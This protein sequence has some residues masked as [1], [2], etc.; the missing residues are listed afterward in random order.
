M[1]VGRSSITFTVQSQKIEVPVKSNYMVRIKPDEQDKVEDP[2]KE[3]S[4]IQKIIKHAEIHGQE[5]LKDVEE[6]LKTDCTADHPDAFWFRENYFV[7]L[8]YKD[9]GSYRPKKASANFMSPSEQELCRNEI[10]QL[11]D[12]K[13][14]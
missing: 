4:K 2:I 7:T 6:T 14:I 5:V 13:L 3:L 12:R 8:P 1:T 9:G 11:L 10:Q